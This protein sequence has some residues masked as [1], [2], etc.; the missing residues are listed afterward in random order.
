VPVSTRSHVH[1]TVNGQTI[2]FLCEPR[3][4]LLEVLARRA[5]PDR[6]S[7][8]A[9]TTATAGACNVVLD[10]ASSN[11]CWCWASESGSLVTTW[12]AWRRRTAHPLQQKFLNTR[13]PVW[14]LHARLFVAAR[15]SDLSPV[16]WRCC[17][18][19]PGATRKPGVQIHTGARR[20]PGTS[21]GA[22][23]RSGD[24]RPSTVVTERPCTSTPSTRHELTRRPSSTTLQAPQ[25]PLL[26]PSLLPSGGARRAGLPGGS[27]AAHTRSRSVCR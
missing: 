15:S 23:S 4:S 27:G 3:Q 12:R 17:P 8:E 11:S 26:Q 22:V 7:K 24:A 25:L 9:A 5:P 6:G 20:V 21:A 16:G 2:D 18:R 14:D 10:A 1:A 13:A 19:L